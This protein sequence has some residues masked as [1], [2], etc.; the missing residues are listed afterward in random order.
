M[1]P[2][3]R[4]IKKIIIMLIIVALVIAGSIFWY[5]QA[6]KAKRAETTSK[7]ET[8]QS[9][10]SDG[11]DR[12]TNIPTGGAQ[13]GAKDNNGKPPSGTNEP[14]PTKTSPNGVIT[15]NGIT[16][17]ALI[18][19]GDSLYGMTTAPGPINF[20]IIDQQSGVIAQGQLNVVNGSFSGKLEFTARSNSGRLDLYTTDAMGSEANNMEIP[21][22]FK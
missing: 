19:S 11:R 7:S 17:N 15:V 13:G 2:A 12:P 3:P 14:V 20:R 9:D 1:K 18:K 4:N 16:D 6:H 8:A 5:S 22:R 21:V 10:Y